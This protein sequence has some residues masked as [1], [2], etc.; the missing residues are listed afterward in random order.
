MRFLDHKFDAQQDQ[1]TVGV[2]PS[3]H[4]DRNTSQKSSYGKPLIRRRN[5]ISLQ[6]EK[7]GICHPYTFRSRHEETEE[8]YNSVRNCSIPVEFQD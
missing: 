4:S 1:N 2:V 6:E 7:E 8:Q 5:L 3:L